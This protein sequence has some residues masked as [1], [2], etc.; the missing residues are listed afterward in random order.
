MSVFDALDAGSIP[1]LHDSLLSLE[2]IR[3]VLQWISAHCGISGNDEADTLAKMGSRQEQVE[4]LATFSEMSTLI[5]SLNRKP[6]QK[7]DYHQLYRKEQVITPNWP[8]K[9]K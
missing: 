2:C 9:A 8:Y 1:P 5:T 3:V 4:T 6:F 7:V